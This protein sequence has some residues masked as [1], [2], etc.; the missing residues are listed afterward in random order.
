MNLQ[1]LNY[2]LRSDLMFVW[3]GIDVDEQLQEVRKVIQ[4]MDNEKKIKNSCLTLPLHISL[5]MSFP[6]LEERLIDVVELLTEYYKTIEPFEIPIDGIEG[7]T[8]IVWIKMMENKCLNRIHNDLNDLL[9]EKFNVGLHE[10][11]R[12]YLF[13]TTLFMDNDEKAI[14]ECYE[15][16]KNIT[17]PSSLKAFKFV[18]GTSKTGD[19]GTYAVIREVF[20]R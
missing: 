10:Y 6:I 12:D 3:I 18:I 13:H 17:L 8:N 20:L 19:L 4:R 2:K 5:K 11:D 1:K 16:I 15:E 14:K 7:H 9:K